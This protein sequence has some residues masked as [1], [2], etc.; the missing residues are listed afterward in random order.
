[1]WARAKPELLRLKLIKPKQTVYSF[2][3]SAAINVFEAS[4]KIKLLQQL[5]GHQSVVTTELYLRSI[6]QIA[7]DVDMM[8]RLPVELK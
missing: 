5:L 1:M 8:P 4:Q 2:R 6:G 7:I 3:H